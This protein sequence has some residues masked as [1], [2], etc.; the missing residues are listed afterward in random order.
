MRKLTPKQEQAVEMILEFKRD[1]EIARVLKVKQNTVSGWKQIPEFKA[2][3][4]KGLA[5]I[6]AGESTLKAEIRMKAW[7]KLIYLID[8]GS[9]KAVLKAL[10]LTEPDKNTTVQEFSV[11]F[12]PPIIKKLATHLENMKDPTE[13]LDDKDVDPGDL[14][15]AKLKD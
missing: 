15:D 9:T 4:D 5:L 6:Y 12:G 11:R 2:A 3:I 1:T 10:D 7:A 13:G 8:L 14:L